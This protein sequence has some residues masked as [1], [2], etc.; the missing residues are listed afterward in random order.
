MFHTVF[1]GPVVQ[2]LSDCKYQGASPMDLCGDASRG[3]VL[4]GCSKPADKPLNTLN[5]C[6]ASISNPHHGDDLQGKLGC[7]CS[8]DDV[9][10][11][12]THTPAITA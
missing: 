6:L 4:P 9:R 2:D 10:P 7:T 8:S 5:T 1:A 3:Y 12:C 11:T